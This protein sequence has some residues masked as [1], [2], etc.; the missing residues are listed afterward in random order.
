MAVPVT[1]LAGS[2]P[3]LNPAK[4][5]RSYWVHA[6][7]GLFTQKGC[8]G[9]EFPATEPPPRQEII[10]AAG[11]LTG[12]YGANR[13]YLIYHKEMPIEDARRIFAWWRAACPASVELVPA[14]LLRMYDKHQTPVFTAAEVRGLG[15]CF[16]ATINPDRVAIYDVSAKRDQGAALAALAERFPNGLIRLG[17]Q[18]T[19]AIAAPFTAAVQDTWSG[20]CHGT[21]NQADWLQPGFGAETLRRW[22]AAR[23]AGTTALVWNLIVVAW[24]YTATK[25]GGYPGYDDAAK[26]LPLPAGRNRCGVR[27]IR[28]TA[29][30]GM[31][32]GFSSDLFILNENSRNA[33]HDGQAA[34]FYKTL[35]DGQVYTGYYAGALREVTQIF[36]ELKSGQWPAE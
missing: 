5:E 21:R 17:A 22:V 2:E 24:D 15:D 28:D 9:A 4:L 12:S 19:E 20:F 35:R 14:L 7:L 25:R 18:P 3:Q 6:S 26:N 13:L 23:N 11:L 32:R 34:A 31:L 8:F 16:H 29:A 27:L 1:G 33:A 10:N 30:P 36:Q